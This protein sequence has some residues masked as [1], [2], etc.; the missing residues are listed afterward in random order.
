[1]YLIIQMWNIPDIEKYYE[2]IPGNLCEVYDSLIKY[3]K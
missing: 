1:M 2:L 3:H